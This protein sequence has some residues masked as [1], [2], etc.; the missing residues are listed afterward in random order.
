[1][2]L[3][4]IMMDVYQEVKEH[5]QG[6][7]T[8]WQECYEIID[9]GWQCMRGERVRMATI[10]EEFSKAKEAEAEAEALAGG[11]PHHHDAVFEYDLVKHVRG[12][13]HSQAR[14]LLLGA[15]TEYGR[16]N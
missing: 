15:V 11:H 10:L 12:L 9:L 13:K 8:L 4:A 14:E 6:A 7:S 5:S 2:G 3:I 16:E 1:M